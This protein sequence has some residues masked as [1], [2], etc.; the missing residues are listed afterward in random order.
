MKRFSKTWNY[1]ENEPN[2]EIGDYWLTHIDVYVAVN[3]GDG[4]ISIV[5]MKGIVYVA[6][7]GVHDR[8]DI[9][10][11]IWFSYDSWCVH[12]LTFI[13]WREL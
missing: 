12:R 3:R 7:D 10:F 4:C 9:M 1:F 13:K 8:W 5:R 11:G 6:N 2:S